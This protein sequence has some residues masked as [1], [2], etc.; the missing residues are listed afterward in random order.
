MGADETNLHLLDEQLQEIDE[1]LSVIEAELSDLLNRQSELI[2]QRRRILEEKQNSKGKQSTTTA[3]TST[4]DA[5]TIP[6][7][8]LRTDFPWS[9][10]L[11]TGAKI[12]FGITE[13]RHRQVKEFKERTY[14]ETAIQQSLPS[15]L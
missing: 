6:P 9:N 14:K 2:E 4:A 13:F 15:N 8:F 3:T 12:L 5:N 7:S 10:A 11:K 1:N